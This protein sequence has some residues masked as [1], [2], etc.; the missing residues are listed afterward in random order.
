MPPFGTTNH[1]TVARCRR[2]G[3]G[4]APAPKLAALSQPGRPGVRKIAAKFGIDPSTVQRISQRVAMIVKQAIWRKSAP[5]ANEPRLG[6][7][8][9]GA[10]VR[11]VGKG[12]GRRDAA[13][14][15]MVGATRQARPAR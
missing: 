9:S 2:L 8:T 13:A 4:D 6:L 5:E 10:F 3:N 7:P 14:A 15:V 11:A 1:Q 12:I